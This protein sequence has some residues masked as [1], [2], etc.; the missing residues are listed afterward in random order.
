MKSLSITLLNIS[1]LTACSPSQK[2]SSNNVI[3]TETYGRVV[4]IFG[5]EGIPNVEV[6]I[7]NNCSVSDANGTYHLYDVPINAEH[8]LIM[9]AEGLLSG[10][11]PISIGSNILEIPNVSL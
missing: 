9:S 10:A 8:I 11:V 4:Q 1:I 6:C 3:S 5:G 7:S 2:D